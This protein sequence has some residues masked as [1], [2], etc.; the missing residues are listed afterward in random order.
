MQ[1]KFLSTLFILILLLHILNFSYSLKFPFKA[2]IPQ[3]ESTSF[4]FSAIYEYNDSPFDM[5]LGDPNVTLLN[6]NI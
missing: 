6:L 4:S 3:S 2:N 1:V 5:D